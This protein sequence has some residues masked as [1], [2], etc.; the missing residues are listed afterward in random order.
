MATGSP[1]PPQ[2]RSS[3]G[4]DMSRRGRIELARQGLRP[5][6]DVGETSHYW[7]SEHEVERALAALG[8]DECLVW[9]ECHEAAELRDERFGVWGGVDMTR[10]P[11]R[12]KCLTRR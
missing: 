4:Q 8:C 9:A 5:R 7:T 11:G 3:Q 10:R 12:A 6:C 1:I 2:T